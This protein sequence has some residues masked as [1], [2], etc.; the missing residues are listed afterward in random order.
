MKRYL[1]ITLIALAC[2]LT[3]G[4]STTRKAAQTSTEQHI[5]SSADKERH[6]EKQTGEAL[7]VNQ[8]M[9]SF[10]NAVIEFTKTEYYDG[11][12]KVDTTG[13]RNDCEATRPRDRESKEPPNV[14]GI[15]SVTTGRIT[16]NNEKNESTETDIKRDSETKTD[17]SISE[18]KSEDNAADTK[19][20][21]KPKRGFIYYFGIIA[22]AIIVIVVILF[23]AYKIRRLRLKNQ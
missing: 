11:M 16:L 17:E 15:K 4:C 23:I 7:N 21:E 19:T 2:C 13:Y 3:V 5:T 22:G 8:S 1:Y 10:T 14:G 12:V 9:N 6:T 18:N 20:E